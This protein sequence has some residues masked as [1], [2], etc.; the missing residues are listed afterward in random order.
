[1]KC[2]PFPPSGS[3]DRLT[4]AT[5]A[6]RR[7][8]R[9]LLTCFEASGFEEVHPPLVDDAFAFAFAG[10]ELPKIIGPDGQILALRADF[11][12]PIARMAASR[13][14]KQENPLKLS[15]VGPV[16][17]Y[18][19]GFRE[20]Y[21]A[22]VELFDAPPEE[23]SFQV[24]QLALHALEALGLS[25]F[26]VLG[27]NAILHALLPHADETLR[28]AL[29]RKSHSQL[30]LYCTTNKLPENI[31]AALHALLS[32]AGSADVLSRAEHML[33]PPCKMPLLALKALISRLPQPCVGVDLALVRTP[34]YYNDLVFDVFVQGVPKAVAGGG[35]YDALT[36]RFGAQRVAVGA[37]FDLEALCSLE[38]PCPTQAPGP[39]GVS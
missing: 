15:Y 14:A 36:Q 23:A 35:R 12:G 5:A 10:E 1:M 30:Q 33:P 3:S 16:F 4:S 9:Q 37:A 31:A 25:P 19:N 20:F 34:S 22:G 26:V 38:A 8:E 29:S 17:R 13:Y 21:Q 7:I 18:R 6:F 32:L 28:L 27:S 39:S 24:V 2:F 11:T